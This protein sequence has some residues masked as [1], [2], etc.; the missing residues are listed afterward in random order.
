LEQGQYQHLSTKVQVP[1]IYTGVNG[2]VSYKL[3]YLA[4]INTLTPVQLNSIPVDQITKWEA[5]FREHLTTKVALLQEI[6]KGM[7][8]LN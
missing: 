4:V 7:L 5:E 1:I 2:H 6:S 3:L 8:P